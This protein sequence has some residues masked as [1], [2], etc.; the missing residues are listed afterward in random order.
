MLCQESGLG[1]PRTLSAWPLGSRRQSREHVL[2]ECVKWGR[3]LWRTIDEISREGM[4]GKESGFKERGFEQGTERRE[5]A[6]TNELLL[7]NEEAVLDF[8][9]E[10]RVGEVEEGFCR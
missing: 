10:T 3:T 4:E 8:S 1:T 6:S 9:K 7:G 5:Q 2:K